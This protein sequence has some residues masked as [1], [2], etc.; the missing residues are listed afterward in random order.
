MKIE[1]PRPLS[2]KIRIGDH[3]YVPIKSD[4]CEVRPESL[5]MLFEDEIIDNVKL[6]FLVNCE[7]IPLDI[8]TACASHLKTLYDS[9]GDFPS[10]SEYFL[11][12][13][14]ER[15]IVSLLESIKQNI[16]DISNLVKKEEQ[17]VDYS[18]SPSSSNERPLFEL[19]D[20]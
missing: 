11:K 1:I 7:Q 20:L 2:W 12:C 14:R 17:A 15:L 6:E 5:R 3:F 16:V 9:V 10:W 19:E 13:N 18:M 8:R 4:G